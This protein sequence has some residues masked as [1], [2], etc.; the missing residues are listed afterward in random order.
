M[1]LR[2]LY[3]CWLQWHVLKIPCCACDRNWLGAID[4]SL[5]LQKI[6]IYLG[7]SEKGICSPAWTGETL[8][9]CELRFFLEMF[10]GP[11]LAGSVSNQLSLGKCWETQIPSACALSFF[12]TALCPVLDNSSKTVP[13]SHCASS[14]CIMFSYKKKGYWCIFASHTHTLCCSSTITDI[15][16]LQS[17][18]HIT[19]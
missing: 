14:L 17:C 7:A 19:I 15:T 5:L 12:P 4:I 18:F 9:Q 2:K 16:S 1:Y 6:N 11:C 13:V 8:S 3:S 10:Q